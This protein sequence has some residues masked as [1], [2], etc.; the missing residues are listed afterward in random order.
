MFQSLS[1][2]QYPALNELAGYSAVVHGEPQFLF[3]LHVLLDGLKHNKK[4]NS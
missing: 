1:V 3:G 4:L 2:E